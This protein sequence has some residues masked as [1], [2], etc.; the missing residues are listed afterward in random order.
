VASSGRRA[1]KHRRFL[2]KRIIVARKRKPTGRPP[3]R[4]AESAEPHANEIR[5]RPIA[6]HEAWELVHPR[7]ARE[8]AED[9][10]EVERMIAGG[11]GE[12]ARDE[13]RWLLDG[14]SDCLIAHKMLGELA[15][16]EGD[17]RL[18]R[19]HFGYAF[20]IGRKAL[21]RAG[22]KTAA[23]YRLP[24]NQAF[25]EAGKGLAYCLRELGKPALVAEVVNRLLQC[26]P[27][28]P[29]GVAG[30]LDSPG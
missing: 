23:P 28:D 7:C 3:R 29:L 26:D 30:F 24:A 4:A 10:Q 6:G 16:A 22:A 13:L 17:L 12:I 11:E 2:G 18:A 20:E 25:F 27:T 21:D 9:L 15:L 5:A 19:G 1:A 8:R 14:C